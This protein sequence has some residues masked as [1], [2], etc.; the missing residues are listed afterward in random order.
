MEKYM[1]ELVVTK[2]QQI[3][4]VIVVVFSII[5]YPFICLVLSIFNIVDCIQKIKSK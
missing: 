5:L 4:R 1:D 2:K 3:L